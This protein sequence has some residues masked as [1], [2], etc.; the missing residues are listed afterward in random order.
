MIRQSEKNKIVTCLAP[1]SLATTNA[2]GQYFR[3]GELNT[4]IGS[5]AA[6][7]TVAGN[8]TAVFLI[9]K[10]TDGI[11][12]GGVTTT[13]ITKTI[14]AATKAQGLSVLVNAPAN[15]KYVTIHGNTYTKAAAYSLANKE[16]SDI[17][18]FI[19]LVNAVDEDLYAVA[20]DGTHAGVYA[21]DPNMVELTDSANAAGWEAAKLFSTTISAQAILEFKQSDLGV[22]ASNVPYTH[23]AVKCTTTATIVCSAVAEIENNDLVQ[24]V[25]QNCEAYLI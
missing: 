6:V 16:F 11:G 7:G 10:A 19:T 14:T 2:T 1:V 13:S 4:V 20:I 17:T 25:T 3:A 23:F 9:F 24:P 22:N 12:T 21:R 5:V 15:G 8:E 18:E